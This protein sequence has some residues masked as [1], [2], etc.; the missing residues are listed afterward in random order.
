MCLL[1]LLAGQ[2]G[3][4]GVGSTVLG[5]RNSTSV[6]GAGSRKLAQGLVHKTTVSVAVLT[7]PAGR[8]LY[9]SFKKYM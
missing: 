6:V 1:Y 8:W 4:R 2:G 3:P 7:W 9:S 5:W